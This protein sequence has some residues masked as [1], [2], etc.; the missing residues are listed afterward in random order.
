MLG[1]SN[2]YN[3]DPRAQASVYLF[4]YPIIL[5]TNIASHKNHTLGF[6]YRTSQTFLKP[7]K[8]FFANA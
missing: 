2:Y 7:K 4:F 6:A 3:Y 8:S 5:K 1:Q